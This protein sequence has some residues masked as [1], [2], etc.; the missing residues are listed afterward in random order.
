MVNQSLLGVFEV[1]G[2]SGRAV[3]ATRNIDGFTRRLYAGLA[4]CECQGVALGTL[5]PPGSRTGLPIPAIRLEFFEGELALTDG[6]HRVEAARRAGL[7]HHRAI[8]RIYETNDVDCYE[9]IELFVRI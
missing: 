3:N 1:S 4:P 2:I 8:V 9:E 5:P 6:N 7:T